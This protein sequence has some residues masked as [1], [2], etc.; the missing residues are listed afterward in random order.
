MSFQTIF[1]RCEL[2]YLLS[3]SQAERI[4]STVASHLTPDP[5]GPASV[6]NLYFDTSSYRLIRHSIEHPVYKEKLRIRCYGPIE[7][8]G[9]VFVELKKKYDGVVYK[10]RLSM[11]EGEAMTWLC[12]QGPC[13]VPTQI[14]REID[15]FL[16]HY[17][18]IGP[19]AL[20]SF[21]REA[22]FSREQTDLR[23]TLDRNV[24]CR[25]TDL[26]LRTPL[27]GTPLLERDQVLMEVKCAG[28]LPL[29]MTRA[30]SESAAYK[31]TFSK[32]GKAYI[33]LIHPTLYT[34]RPSL[35]HQSQEELTHA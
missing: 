3:T 20:I 26:S 5:Y 29:W 1:E 9:T 21:D 31:T 6:R 23:V 15:Y 34:T 33:A 22:Y 10:R 16:H 7:E 25:L 24:R 17:S 13:P 18:T 30:L 28:G 8:D 4:L 32:Y 14:G 35:S 19:K 12:G 27:S 11:K 2:K